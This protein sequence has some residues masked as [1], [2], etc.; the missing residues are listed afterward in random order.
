MDAPETDALDTFWEKNFDDK[1]SVPWYQFQQAFLTNYDANLK[2]ILLI[3][4]N[5]NTDYCLFC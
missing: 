5:N 4:N 3:N 1:E 2:G